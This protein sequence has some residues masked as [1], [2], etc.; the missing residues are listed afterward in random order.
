[1]FSMDIGLPEHDNYKKIAKGAFVRPMKTSP[2]AWMKETYK[3]FFNSFYQDIRRLTIVER[4]SST[5][6][7]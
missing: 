6:F 4:F 3:N 1:M 5:N 7:L 2:N